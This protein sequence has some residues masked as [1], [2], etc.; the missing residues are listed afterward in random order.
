ML[1]SYQFNFNRYIETNML[2][3]VSGCETCFLIKLHGL[4]IQDC[5]NN[6]DK[7]V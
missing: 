6:R 3:T 7:S 4:V 5:R 2:V 1:Q